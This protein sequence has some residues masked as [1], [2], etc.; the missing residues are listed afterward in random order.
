ME[1]LMYWCDRDPQNP[2]PP[3]GVQTEIHQEPLAYWV[4]ETQWQVNLSPEERGGY[5]PIWL[6]ET[7]K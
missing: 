2:V 6:W 4:N 5:R 3:E 7:R 1:R